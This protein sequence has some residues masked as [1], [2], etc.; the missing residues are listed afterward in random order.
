LDDSGF[1]PVDYP[2]KGKYFVRRK[3]K[4]VVMDGSYSPGRD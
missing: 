1:Q 3:E 2:E 4:F